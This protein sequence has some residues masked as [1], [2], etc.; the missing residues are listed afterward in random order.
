MTAAEKTILIQRLVDTLEDESVSREYKIKS[1]K[2]YRDLGIITPDQ[3]IDYAVDY[4]SPK[5]EGNE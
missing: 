5:T 2:N 4:I 3:A 1:I